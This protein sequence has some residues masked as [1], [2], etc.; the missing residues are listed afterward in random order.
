MLVRILAALANAVGGTGV[1]GTRLKAANVDWATSW[2]GTDDYG[3]EVLPAGYYNG[4]FNNV[5]SNAN[6]WAIT[7]SGSL[8]Y[9]RRFDSGATMDQNTNFKYYGYSVRLVKDS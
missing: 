9:F 2:G 3:F 4:S 8:A 1:A 7:E 6:F 5:G